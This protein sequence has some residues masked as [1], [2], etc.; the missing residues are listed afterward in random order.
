MLKD[1]YPYY[2][3]SEPCFAN[4]DLDVTNK[5][6][7]E[8]A[9]KVALADAGV[10]DKAIA[11]AEKAQPAMTALAPY[12][13][14]AILE[15]CVKRFTEREE[16]LGKA[17]CIEAGKPIKDAKGEVAR[18]IDTFKIA[19]EESVRINGEV[20]NLEISARAKG[21]QGMTKKVP[22]GPC[23]FISP[24]NFPLNLAAHKVAPAIAAGCTFVLKPASRTPIGALII[25]EVLAECELMPKGAFSILP[26]S[27]DGA[28]LFTTDERLKLLSFTG[29][30]DVGWAL[31]AKAGKKPVV[32]ELGGNAACVVDE[33]ADISD[34]ID[35][36]I[37]GA[38]YQSGQSCISVQRLLVHSSIYDDFKSRYVERV[39]ALVSGDPSDEDTFIGPMISEG[40]A[41]RLDGW[42]KDAKE[43]GASVLCGGERDGA[44][45]QATV[46]ENVPKDC[47]ASAEEAFGPLSILQPF[48][49]YDSALEEVNNSR[50]GLQAGIF[51]RDIY[52]AHKAWN[53]L[54][55]GG[56]V[57]G[58]VPSWRVDNMPYGGVKDSGLGREGIRYAIEDMTETRLMVIRTP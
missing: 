27:R 17:L 24:F 35:R 56:V 8:V 52:K 11:A 29:S 49:D 31:K 14:Q 20:V 40:E 15:Y 19:A 50:Y 7:G 26:C 10:I 5:Y 9:T 33:D 41:K 47:D 22:I 16:E 51:T 43:A 4:T 48:D 6:T 55:V 34:A 18:L 39:K 25:G 44:M 46:M 13:R 2:L 12:E 37:V 21:Y 42:I 58:D 53:V 45:L 36:I 3:A 32:L 57:I 54:E 28:D 38:Y 23:S 30:P 1:S